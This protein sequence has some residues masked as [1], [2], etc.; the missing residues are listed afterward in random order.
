MFIVHSTTEEMD[1]YTKSSLFFSLNSFKIYDH[2]LQMFK[3]EN[4]DV[5]F[6][7]M[8]VLINRPDYKYQSV[9]NKKKNWTH[10]LNQGQ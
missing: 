7:D 8:G 10:S 2:E 1:F 4:L 6:R 9:L 5:I 3:Y